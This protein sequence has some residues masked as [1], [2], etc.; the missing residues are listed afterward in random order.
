[1]ALWHGGTGPLGGN[2]LSSAA[3]RGDAIAGIISSLMPTGSGASEAIRRRPTNVWTEAR[4]AVTFHCSPSTGGPLGR[5]PEGGGGRQKGASAKAATAERMGWM[6]W[7]VGR[8]GGKRG[9]GWRR[10][11]SSPVGLLLLSL[12]LQKYAPKSNL[13]NSR[14]L[15]CGQPQVSGSKIKAWGSGLCSERG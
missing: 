13:V 8:W 11:R 5:E 12:P 3:K 4:V 10:W 2:W 9:A 14:P 1:M 7:M 6:G 15:L